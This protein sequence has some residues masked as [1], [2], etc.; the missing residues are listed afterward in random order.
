M[1]VKNY[2]YID[3]YQCFEVEFDEG[4]KLMMSYEIFEEY[5]ISLDLELSDEEFEEIK[6]FSDI[7]FAKRRALVFLSKR[8]KTK[9]EVKRK[10]VELGFDY[11]VADE[12]VSFLEEN[13][14]LNDREYSKLFIEEKINLNGY[15]K[16]K[17][18]SLL[19]QKG[20]SN[21]DFYDLLED[22]E[23]DVEFENA[24]EMGKKKR[25]QLSD[26][27]EYKIRKK[28]FSFLSYRGFGY[29][30]INRVLREII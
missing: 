4:T 7:E 5:N 17:I 6:Y 25:R 24:L 3:R 16:N 21:D 10:L 28:L 29:D 14:Y 8:M 18:K 1:I 9:V 20:V 26:D 22:I 27:D 23:N 15:G 19:V 12:V 2:D 11:S 30:V 13:S